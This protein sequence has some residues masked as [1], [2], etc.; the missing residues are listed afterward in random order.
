M[1]LKRS[2]INKIRWSFGE[3][4]N[5]TDF[6][7]LL[8]TVNSYLYGKKAIEFNIDQLIKITYQ[9]KIY[10][11]FYISKK[12]GGVREIYCP[13]KYL[14]NILKT[15]NVILQCIYIPNG[16]AHGFILEKSVVTNAE[17]HLKKY[18]VFNLDL[19]DFFS[20]IYE[21]NILNKLQ[22]EPFNLKDGKL[23]LANL[24]SSL[25][26]YK[27]ENNSYSFLP[28]GAPTSPIISN[29]VCLNLDKM[30]SKLAKRF[31]LTYSRYADDISFSSMHNV[32][33]SDS[34]FIKELSNIIKSQKFKIN[35]SKIRLQKKG[36][37]QVVTGIVVNEKTNVFRGYIRNL[38][39]LIHLINKN[40][41]KKAQ[42]IYDGF[43]NNRYNN[44]KAKSGIIDVIYGKLDYLKM[45]KG[46]QD[47][48]YLKLKRKFEKIIIDKELILLNE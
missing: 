33:Q 23:V 41:I 17:N 45:V 8:N 18:F 7:N 11:K 29:I 46:N 13:N 4:Q 24:I 14:K 15:L 42:I 32:Y 43:K 37:R 28:Q 1:N 5:L 9:K 47:E 44:S 6:V 22:L 36:Y 21:S 40:N 31:D 16:Y 10:T 39:I 2:Y 26:C 12:N 30:L 35:R 27:P 38:R 20:S 25:C 3:M 19:Q 48:T 34:L